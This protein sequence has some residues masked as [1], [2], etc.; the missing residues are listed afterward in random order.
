MAVLAGVRLDASARDDATRH[1]PRPCPAWW[2][3]S[4]AP[5]RGSDSCCLRLSLA[6]GQQ[7]GGVGGGQDTLIAPIASIPSA[8]APQRPHGHIL[9]ANPHGVVCACVGP[10]CVCVRVKEK[11]SV[12]S[13][14][15]W[16]DGIGGWNRMDC[17]AMG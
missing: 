9:C 16:E 8:L 14:L 5:Q 7:R 1:T 4:H 11:E 6:A 10:V 15:G 17:D 2:L 12:S 13:T 3:H